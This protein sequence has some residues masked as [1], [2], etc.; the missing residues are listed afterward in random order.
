MSVYFFKVSATKAL[1]LRRVPTVKLAGWVLL[2]K[3]L[4]QT[5]H[6]CQWTVEIVSVIT[7]SQVADAMWSAQDTEFVSEISVSVINSL[8]GEAPYVKCLDVQVLMEETA[9]EME[10]VTVQT[11][12]ASV[13]QV[14]KGEHLVVLLRKVLFGRIKH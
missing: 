11:I 2:V 7:A 3:I 10:N 5:E 6:R 1:I 8:V 14:G 4:A 13:Y 12:N 9:V